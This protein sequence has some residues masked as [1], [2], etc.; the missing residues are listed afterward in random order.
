MKPRQILIL[1]KRELIRTLPESFKTAAWLLVIMVPIS[2]AVV[3]LDFLGVTAWLSRLLSPLFG[4]LGLPGESALAFITGGLLNVYTGIAVMSAMELTAGQVTV[5]AFMILTAHNLPVET[6]VQKKTGSG[7]IGILLLRLSAA[8]LGG[9]IISRIL[10]MD[11]GPLLFS[12]TAEAALS[13]FGP[14]FLDWAERTG[15]LALKI[16]LLV[17]GLT[18]LQNVIQ[19]FGINKYLSAFFAPVMKIFGLSR[20]VSFLW[21]TANTLGL[22]YGSAVLI[23]SSK[24]GEVSRRD[25]DLLNHHIAL[26]HSLLEDT[27]LF[28]ALGVGVFWLTVPRLLFAAAAVWL[29][30]AVSGRKE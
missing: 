24:E 22:A 29:N 1:L 3:V 5:L 27:L 23:K 12:G 11:E 21:I 25:A 10:P 9:F 26:S 14:V 15:S 13:S 8:F 17:I 20:D 19:G 6:A 7:G 30:R 18:F 2:F 16:V 28:A 4:I